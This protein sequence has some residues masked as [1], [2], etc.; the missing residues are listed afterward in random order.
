[1]SRRLIAVLVLVLGVLAACGRSSPTVTAPGDYRLFVAE[2]YGEGSQLTVRDAA[3]GHLE[4]EL[5]LGV[6]APDWSRY[7]TVTA[8]RS[9]SRLAAIDPATGRTLGQVS[10]PAGF[11]LPTLTYPQLPGGL[12]PNGAWLAL[13][14]QVTSGGAVRSDFL[15]GSTS[16]TKAF[17]RLSLVGD[18]SFDAIS[19]DGSSLYL[20]ETIDTGH[21]RVRLYDVGSRSLTPQPIADKREPNE[22]MNG[23]RGD[24]VPSPDGSY[25]F[26][27]Y[28]RDSGP[29][30][31]ALALGQPYAWCI[32]L[33]SGV[34][35]NLEDQFQWSLV[36]NRDGSRIYAVNGVSGQISELSPAKLP[37][38]NRTGTVSL[39]AAS[40]AP[41]AALFTDAE[42]KGVHVSG[43]AL[44]SDGRTLF[45]L[46]NAGILAIDT[47]TLKTRA[48]YLGGG[49]IMSV[50][51]SSDGRWL[52]AADIEHEQILKIDPNTGQVAGQIGALASPWAVLWAEPK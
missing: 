19:N 40:L 20:I 8:Y 50:R 46:D 17:S 52:F 30:I 4:R 34:T 21:Y 13:T 27:I 3:T 11:A 44:S 25:V 42:A 1:M 10:I 16:L 6:P 48:R 37:A 39:S 45:A 12:S 5:P 26:T 2:G 18:F 29:F 15:V 43:A 47:A 35:S 14:R 36:S 7:Y 9:V 49:A 31:H 38:V 22:P 23:I 41:V 32:D 28:A 33:P 51:M 24:S